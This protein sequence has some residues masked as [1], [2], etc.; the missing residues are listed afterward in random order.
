MWESIIGGSPAVSRFA[1]RIAF[2]RWP[3]SPTTT[4]RSTRA[5]SAARRRRSRSRS[6]S[7]SARA[8]EA[9]DRA[10]R[11]LRLRRR[12]QRGHDARQ[13]RGLPAPA[14]RA[15]DAARRRRARPLDRRC[16]A[17]RCRRRCCWRRSACRRSSTTEGELATA[18]A[19]AALGLPM[20]AST[21]SALH[22][23]GDRRGRRR[24]RRAGSSS[25]GPTT[26]SSPRA[27]SAAPRRPATARSSLTVD[28]FV[29]G[30]KPRDL[31]QAWLPFLKGMGIAN[32]FQD[33][34]FR[35]GAG[36]DAGGGRRRRH[37]PL[38]RRPGQPRAEL[39][40]P[41]L[42][43]RADLA[44]D[45]GQGDPAPRRR[46]RGGASAASTASSSP[47][48]AAAR[49]TARSPRSTRCRR[50]PRRSATSWRS[51][52]TAASAAAPT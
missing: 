20:I 27:S 52:S 46:P 51:S 5:A 35:A 14:D 12:R 11:Q 34:V 10:R 26:A 7:W 43:A 32:Y 40:R 17:P 29:P 6:P 42:A 28:T 44:A 45:P 9:M 4:A 38:P 50:S 47:T 41:R 19:A 39:G 23:R 36:E 3:T 30:W 24:R 8:A 16:S 48:T 25:T 18:R 21:A 37:R 22:A 1:S 33:P 15:A 49:S 31:Q 2:R 13:P